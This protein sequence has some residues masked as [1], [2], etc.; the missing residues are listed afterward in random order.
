MYFIDR[1]YKDQVLGNDSGE[2]SVSGFIMKGI[3]P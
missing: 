3:E 2:R 1:S